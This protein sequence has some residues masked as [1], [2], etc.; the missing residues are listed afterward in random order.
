MK[1]A[2]NAVGLAPGGGLSFLLNQI[3]WFEG[4]DDSW[5]FSYFASP[6]C[7][8]ALRE[9][10]T[11]GTVAVPFARQPSYSERFLWEQLR[12]PRLL[13]REGYDALYCAG[14]YAV[15]RSPIPQLVVDQNP[16]HFAGRK[17]LGAGMTL[18]VA[19]T[20]RELAWASVRR[21]EST[22]YVS[23][24]FAEAMA[25]VGFPP[26][27][28]VIRSGANV[29][30]PAISADETQV[31]CEQCRLGG[32]A[33]AVHNWYPHKRLSW[34]TSAWTATSE[35][36]AQHLLLVGRALS[37]GGRREMQ[38]VQSSLGPNSPVHIV[39]D[40]RRDEVA[41]IYSQADLYLSASVLE[42]FP[43]TPFEAMS[44][45]VP[46][47]LSDIPPH[48]EVADSAATFFKVGDGRSFASAVTAAR[49]SR[50]T[51][52]ARGRERIRSFQ[53]PDHVQALLDE[54]TAVGSAVRLQR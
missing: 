53:W 1:V 44:F 3:Q 37:R 52:S 42:A 23:H 49:A 5:E 18:A 54:L 41:R 26:P 4:L 9:A 38:R 51:L 39:S 32:Y 45:S 15:F 43:L 16:W 30:F 40:A 29:D 34:L 7:E 8:A 21:A 36:N 20:K 25:S 14:S 31:Q 19:R 12:F 27:T 47:V 11:H 24:S 50:D 22:V 48:R 28:R 6:R 13:K 33:L 10:V 17:E 2:V 46:C 35:S